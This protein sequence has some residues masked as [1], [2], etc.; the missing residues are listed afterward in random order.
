MKPDRKAEGWRWIEQAEADR[1]G[2]Q[3]LFEGGSYHLACFIAQQVAEKA[4]KAYIY[5]QGEEFVNCQT[6]LN[7]SAI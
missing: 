6:R 7:R 2:L 5:A 3:L 1:Q 4:L